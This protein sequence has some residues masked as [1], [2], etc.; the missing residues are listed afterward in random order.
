MLASFTFLLPLDSMLRTADGLVY[1]SPCVRDPSPT[2]TL[3]TVVGGCS[4]ILDLVHSA[5][6]LSLAG[7]VL[8]PVPGSLVTAVILSCISSV[9]FPQSPESPVISVHV[10][11]R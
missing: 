4:F 3:G 11:R 7:C 1:N 6:S 8:P 10:H 5:H 9:A 2:S